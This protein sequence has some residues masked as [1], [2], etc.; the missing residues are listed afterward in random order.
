[1]DDERTRATGEA[2]TIF[3]VYAVLMALFAGGMFFGHRDVVTDVQACAPTG[4]WL[5]MTGAEWG[6]LLV[7]ANLGA[8]SAWIMLFTQW[9]RRGKPWTQLHPLIAS[10]VAWAGLNVWETTVR[11]WLSRTGDETDGGL[12]R[13]VLLGYGALVFVTCVT[14]LVPIFWLMTC[15]TCPTGW[16]GGCTA[17]A[18]GPAGSLLAMIMYCDARMKFTVPAEGPEHTL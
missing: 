12:P 10:K 2:R 16:D 7:Y 13:T 11:T 4:D 5:S 6:R 14:A 8:G 1:V 9:W 3:R 18:G 17:S 15:A